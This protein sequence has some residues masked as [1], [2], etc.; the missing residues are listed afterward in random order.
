SEG[1]S[2][3]PWTKGEDA[4]LRALGGQF[5]DY[6]QW[7]AIS[8]SL[9]GR[10]AVAGNQRWWDHL[11]PDDMPQRPEATGEGDP[12]TK[13]EDALLMQNPWNNSIFQE[14]SDDEWVE[15]DLGTRRHIDTLDFPE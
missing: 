15:D 12:W 2:G 4:L 7:T 13:E 1:S 8:E 11:A 9:S 14:P 10:N 6:G 5:G 3:D